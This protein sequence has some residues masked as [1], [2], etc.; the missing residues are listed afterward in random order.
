M[1]VYDDFY[2]NV[3]HLLRELRQERKMTLEKLGEK[4]GLS[5]SYI[6]QVE[7]GKKVASVESYV[8]LFSNVLSMSKFF[9]EEVTTIRKILNGTFTHNDILKDITEKIEDFLGMDGKS[10]YLPFCMLENKERLKSNIKKCFWMSEF[11]NINGSTYDR[12]LNNIC[13]LFEAY[14][15]AIDSVNLSDTSESQ[16]IIQNFYVSIY[17]ALNHFDNVLESYST[18]IKINVFNDEVSLSYLSELDNNKNEID[19]LTNLKDII[20]LSDDLTEFEKNILYS[21]LKTI[22][23]Y[24]EQINHNHC[25]EEN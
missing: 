6:A 13:D 9:D 12:E 17:D 4:T 19:T 23:D 15:S 2:S 8:L 20:D 21:S 22:K 3:G 11:L 5:Y 10:V 24:R 18:Y 25:D 7:K 1:S 16:D 14:I